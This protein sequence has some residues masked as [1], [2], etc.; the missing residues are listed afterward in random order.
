MPRDPSTLANLLGPGKTYMRNAI[1]ILAYDQRF[2]AVDRTVAR[3]ISRV[4]LG[5][6]PSKGRPHSEGQILKIGESLV[7]KARPRDYHLALLDFA[8]T[9]CVPRTCAGGRRIMGG[10]CRFCERRDD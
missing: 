4:F 10:I 8:A 5:V 7:P 3:V 9:V 1:L 2:A 6:E